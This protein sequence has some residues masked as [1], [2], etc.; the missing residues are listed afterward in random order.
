MTYIQYIV[1]MVKHIYE[2]IYIRRRHTYGDGIHMK[3]KNIWR[4]IYTKRH[5]WRDVHINKKT[6]GRAYTQ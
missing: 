6:Q 2:A 3:E 4:D 5:T 1:Y